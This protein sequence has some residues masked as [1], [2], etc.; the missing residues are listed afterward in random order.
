MVML[1]F[2]LVI[3]NMDPTRQYP[4]AWDFSPF[5][6]LCGGGK[7]AI[8]KQKEVDPGAAAAAETPASEDPRDV[9]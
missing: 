3:N 7:V 9:L 8:Q 4:L 1:I 5:A 6:G 2:A